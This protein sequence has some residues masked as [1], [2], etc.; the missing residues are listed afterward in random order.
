M[1]IVNVYFM[2]IVCKRAQYYCRALRLHQYIYIYIYI[3][4]NTTKLRKAKKAVLRYSAMK[5]LLE[6][7]FFH[8]RCCM[9]EHKVC[10]VTSEPS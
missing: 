10:S 8:H 7:S 9:D 5:Q 1:Q 2:S 3:Y 6:A 4:C